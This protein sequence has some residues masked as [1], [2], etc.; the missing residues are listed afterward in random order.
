MPDQISVDVDGHDDEREPLPP[1]IISPAPALSNLPFLDDSW[2]CAAAVDPMPMDE[3]DVAAFADTTVDWDSM[4][5]LTQYTEG[6][7]SVL[8]NGTELTV[9]D[10]DY[11]VGDLVWASV[12]K[13]PYWPAIVCQE[14]N[15][16]THY[17]G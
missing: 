8:F 13:N 7:Q 12:N 16:A 4:S 10:L 2:P 14:Y 15:T 9:E 5:R 11:Q 1:P 6:T 3:E 17:Q